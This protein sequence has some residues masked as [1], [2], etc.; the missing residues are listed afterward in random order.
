MCSVWQGGA[1]KSQ[2]KNIKNLS[3]F[4]EQKKL[5]NLKQLLN[6]HWRKTIKLMIKSIQNIS[7]GLVYKEIPEKKRTLEDALSSHKLERA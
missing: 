3:F 2:T 7:F 6:I 1:E 5:K 4:S